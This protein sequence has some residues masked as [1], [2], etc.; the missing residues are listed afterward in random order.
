MAI[1]GIALAFITI[2]MLVQRKV[3]LGVA[4]L[5]GAVI[6]GLSSGQGPVTLMRVA[7]EA[8]VE[9]TAVNLILTLAMIST[10]G[11]IMQELGILTKMVDL[12]QAVLRSTKL[13]I[14][15]VPSIIGTLLVTGGAIMSA[16]TVGQ[17]GEELE[18][19]PERL[20]A[21]NLL[22]RH[23]WYFVYPL[24]PAFVL[25]TSITGVSLLTLILAQLPLTA[26][27]L[28]T[29]YWVYL[30]KVPDKGQDKPKPT[31]V[32]IRGLVQYT[33]PIWASLLLTVALGLPFPVALIAGLAL[34]LFLG[35]ATLLRVPSLLW[36]GISIP[37][38]LS[39]AGIMVFKAV[40]ERVDAL[41]LLI[42]QL[43]QTGLPVRALFVLLPFLAGLVSASNTS[44]L[45]LTLPLLLPTMQNNDL[46]LFGTVAAYTSSF[47]GYYASPLHLCQVVTLEHFNCKIVPLYKQYMWPIM[48]L[49]VT[50][51]GLGF[52]L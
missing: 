14:M 10:L 9:P 15:L 5:V 32:E 6:V 27:V 36:Q 44:A 20:S 35:K 50:L 42:E 52:V 39:G 30:R 37:I 19:P 48:A 51:V 2:I 41:P 38:V 13:T 45:G 29:G 3:I 17:L 46:V 16:P 25:V 12:L 26:A 22:F 40:T 7:F 28:I 1:A 24:M 18:L 23:G 21:I 49:I 34:A 8:L 11:Y 4:L 47:I 33:S 31:M 43:L